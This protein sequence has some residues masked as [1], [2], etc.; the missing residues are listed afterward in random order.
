MFLTIDNRNYIKGIIRNILSNLNMIE[1]EVVHDKCCNL[2]DFIHLKFLINSENNAKKDED[3]FNQL[4]RNNNREIISILYLLLPFIEDSN[5]YEKFKLIKNLSDITLLKDG[6]K[7]KISNFQYSRGYN[8]SNDKF[9]EYAF[10]VEDININFEL[11]KKTI[12]RLRMKMYVNWINVVPVLIEKYH[13]TQLYKNSLKYYQDGID[14]NKEIALPIS[15]YY[16]T[17]IND[18]YYNTLEFKWLLFEKYENDRLITYIDILNEIYPVYS[19]LNN[20]ITSKWILLDDIN[21]NLFTKNIDLFFSKAQNKESYGGFSGELLYDFFIYLLTFFDT[22]YKFKK[23]I[24]EYRKVYNIEDD[25]NDYNDDATIQENDTIRLLRNYPIIDKFYLYD[26]IRGQILKL[27]KTWYGYKMFNNNKIVQLYEYQYIQNPADP[28]HSKK[29]HRYNTKDDN[30]KD[31]SNS[32]NTTS[33]KENIS[34]KNIYNF[35]KSLFLLNA[36]IAD[37]KIQQYL[38]ITNTLYYDNKNKAQKELIYDMTISLQQSQKKLKLSNESKTK[39]DDLKIKM[40]NTIFKNFNISKNLKKKY[41]EYNLPN[42]VIKQLNIFII[43]RIND[44][45]LDI[46]FECLC[47]KGI[48]SEYIIRDDKFEKNKLFTSDENKKAFGKH[49][50]KYEDA[51]YYINDDRYKDLNKI[52]NEKTLKE[53]TYFDRLEK[54]EKWYTFYAMDWVSQINFYHHYINQRIVMLTGGTGVGKSTQTPKLLLYGLKAFDKKFDG[55]VICTQPRIAPTVNNASRISAELGVNIQEYNKVY[56]KIVKTTNGIIQYKYEKDDHIDED[57]DFY[58]RIVTDGSLL[59]ELQKSPLLKQEIIK[60]RSDFEIDLD[61]SISLKNIYDIVIVDESHEHNANM[62]LILSIVRGSVFLNNQLRLYIIS[63]TMDA[64]DPIYRKYYR[65]INDNLKYPINDLYNKKTELYEPLLDRIVIDRRIHISPPGETTQYKITEIYHDKDFNENEEQ[66]AYKLA[67][68]YAQEICINNVP[69]ANSDILLFCT[70]SNKIIKLVD[71]LNSILPLNTLVIPF[72]KDLPEESKNLI[73]TNLFRIKKN[74]KFERRYIHDVLNLKINPDNINS[75]YK[76]DRILIVSTNI[77]EASITIDSLKYVIDTGFNLDVSYN[78]ESETTNIQVVKISEASRLQRKGRVGRVGD[79]AVYYTYPKN[80]R[81]DIMPTYN[82]CK[83]NFRDNFLQ[84]LE[85]NMEPH[86]YDNLYYPYLNIDPNEP[87]LYKVINYLNTSEREYKY[88]DLSYTTFK[89]LFKKFI[90]NQ[91]ATTSI[92]SNKFI[93][94]DSLYNIDILNEK[95]YE[96][97]IGFN[98]TGFRNYQLIDPNLRFYLIHPFE[99]DLLKYR[100]ENTRML[101]DINKSSQN[102]GISIIIEKIVSTKLIYPLINNLYVYEDK[103]KYIN[104]IKI[105]KNLYQLRQKTDKLM[106]LNLFH[107]IIAGYKLGIFENILFIAYFLSVTKYNLMSIVDNIEVF[108]KFFISKESDLLV[109][110][111]IFE[112]FK[113]T[114]RHILFESDI[115]KYIN[116]KENEFKRNYYY[117]I[118]KYYYNINNIQYDDFIKILLKNDDAE[119]HLESL[120]GTHIPED[121]PDYIENELKNWCKLYG[122]NFR[123]FMGIIKNYRLQYCQYKFILDN[124][125]YNEYIRKSLIN[126][127]LNIDKNIIK[128]FLHGNINNIFIYD[129]GI[130]SNFKTYG[131]PYTYKKN[132]F[133][134]KWITEVNETHFMLILNKENEIKIGSSPTGPPKIDEEQE[135]DNKVIVLNILSS[136][137]SNMYSNI[138]YFRDNPTNKNYYQLDDVNHNFICNNPINIDYNKHPDDPKFNE[139]INLLKTSMKEYIDRNC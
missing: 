131:L 129:K 19:I 111:K 92:L 54:S 31:Y 21:K 32:V 85:E 78:Y 83:I 66:D 68:K 95:Y 55:K 51:Y 8:D 139:Y 128:S 63:A 138:I 12:E 64:D 45:S 43:L 10:S 17:I 123:S 1:F 29:Q 14:T 137:S 34:Y 114:Y 52:I 48:L 60:K 89:G 33:A 88:G 69:S 115:N 5:N 9:K 22:K 113:S 72:Y 104:K 26:F 127:E 108:T 94:S 101:K 39:K 42:D 87:D 109:I 62:D 6:K 57:L 130:Y 134:K 40:Q 112:L 119:K 13:E 110:N 76:Y 121:I 91:Y 79:G 11:L 20:K 73:T 28:E 53:E 97:I 120:N 38:D 116:N 59:V 46:V 37:K 99:Y 47:K 50:K 49:I 70:T 124:R 30:I 58:L 132:T 82:I 23:D 93:Y 36:P 65:T 18:L 74:F 135:T 96:D 126:D 106:E 118:N 35:A 136:I 81:L 103:D 2:I 25:E 75:V 7:Y 71:E 122:I 86:I 80:S 41:I 27:S 4:K 98:R 107:P 16:D 117:F 84:L 90:I 125:K 24:K 3:F 67:I 44:I 102:N 61:K 15:E 77:A 100:D 133:H 105:V 56:K